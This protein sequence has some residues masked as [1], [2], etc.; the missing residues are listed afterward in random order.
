VTVQ[1]IRL[2]LSPAVRALAARSDPAPFIESTVAAILAEVWG[3]HA[4]NPALMGPLRAS[5]TDNVTSILSLFAGRL[6][7]EDISP[8]AN[9]AFTDL[10]VQVGIPVSEIESAYWIGMVRFWRRWLV[11]AGEA[12]ALGEGSMYEFVGAP[13]EALMHHLRHVTKMVVDHY[14]AL[15]E[16]MR[17]TQGDRRRMLI[18]QVVEGEP[19]FPLDDIEREL[20]YR[21]AGTHL[22]LALQATERARVEQAVCNLAERVGAQSSLLTVHGADMWVCW[23]RFPG[24]VTPDCRVAVAKAIQDPHVLVTAG[25]PAAGVGGFRRT[26]SDALAAAALRRRF[27]GFDQFLWFRDVSLELCLLADE[28]AARRF[29]EDELGRL[30]TS[31]ERVERARE[32][33]LAWLSCGSSSAV[34]SRFFLHENTVRMRVSQAQELLPSELSGRRAEVLAALRLRALLGEP[35]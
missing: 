24:S 17:R 25:E 10:A 18:T 4:S 20:N 27:E 6:R 32:T 14:E 11:I 31:G 34:A 35:A 21:F 2:E 1:E 12:E 33:L 13:T 30:N 23:L 28:H 7:I 15:A 26:R 9:F 8:P 22:G 3:H 19:A 16:T 29:V 5:V